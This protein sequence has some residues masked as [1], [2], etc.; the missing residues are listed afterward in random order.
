MTWQPILVL[1][2]TGGQGGAVADALLEVVRLCVRWCVNLAM[3]ERA[4]SRGVA[5]T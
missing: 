3:T 5:W 1:G 2:A 4:G